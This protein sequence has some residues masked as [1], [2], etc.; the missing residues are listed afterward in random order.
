M[1][2]AYLFQ[3]KPA[4]TT[5]FNQTCFAGQVLLGHPSKQLNL[6]PATIIS[7]LGQQTQYSLGASSR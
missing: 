2:V 1:S 7:N 4:L 6:E 3:V 5:C